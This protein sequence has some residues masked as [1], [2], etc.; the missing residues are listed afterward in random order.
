METGVRYTDAFKQ[1]AVNPG[2][3]S[4]LLHISQI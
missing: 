4:W 1:E 3:C 2:I